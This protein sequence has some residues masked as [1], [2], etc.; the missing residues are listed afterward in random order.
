MGDQSQFSEREKQVIK[1]LIQGKSNKQIALALD[2]ALRTVEF[3]LSNIY[4][5]LGVNSRTEAALQ[6]SKTYLRESAGGELRES[7][8]TEMDESNDNS[9]TS[10]SPRRIPMNK[11]F[12]IGL[13]ILIATV[14][15][16]L[17]SILLMAKQRSS[18]QAGLLEPSS[19]PTSILPASTKTLIPTVLPKEHI[20]EQ[21]R[22][23][24]DYDIQ[25]YT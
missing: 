12:L 15:F 21:I 10:I 17:V 7:T 25:Q 6:L 8:V 22:Q 19:M 4:A 18:A 5:K 16:C 13:V 23:W 24:A 20:L 14:M 2:I 9:E 1:L 3:H 11:S